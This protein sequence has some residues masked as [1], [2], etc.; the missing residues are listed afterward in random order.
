MET[1][2]CI[3]CNIEKNINQFYKNKQYKSNRESVCKDCRK[4][5]YWK[6]KDKILN[7]VH[8]YYNKNCED[9]KEYKKK[10]RKN[11]SEII[12]VKRKERY[13]KNR[14]GIIQKVKIYYL[15]NKDYLEEKKKI[16]RENNKEKIQKYRKEYRQNNK[17]KINDYFKKRYNNDYIYKFKITIRNSINRY[18]RLKGKEKNKCTEQIIGCDFK[19]LSEHLLQTYKKNYG[20]DWDKKEKVHID[21][22]IPLSTAKNEE[23]IIKLNHYTNLQLLKEKDNLKKSNKLDWSL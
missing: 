12:K 7:K 22:I 8:E 19:Y 21:H 20:V 14:E 16:Y 15:E 11:N 1:K 4:E 9:I 18:I 2:I 6:N 10:Y 23:D 13:E 5:Y 17:E 3:K